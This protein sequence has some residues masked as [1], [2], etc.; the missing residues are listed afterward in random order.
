[1]ESKPIINDDLKPKINPL[2]VL[3]QSF[4]QRNE[5]ILQ[6]KTNNPNESKD[7]DHIEQRNNIMNRKRTDIAELKLT[8]LSERKSMTRKL[9][10]PSLPVPAQSFNVSRNLATIWDEATESNNCNTI[11][12][13][14]VDKYEAMSILTKLMYG[15]LE[16][17]DQDDSSQIE[18]LEEC[19]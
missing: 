1:M 7:D 3:R 9:K 12:E 13:S 4:S 15:V 5:E 6:F 14:E 8:S 11:N 16:R 2:S 18:W 17:F 19:K 10:G